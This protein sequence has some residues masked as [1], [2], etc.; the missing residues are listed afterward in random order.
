MQKV[1]IKYENRKLY[2]K[3]LKGY[4]SLQELENY[5]INNI[6]FSVIKHK[7]QEDITNETLVRVL[8]NKLNKSSNKS[9]D[10]LITLI[11][12]S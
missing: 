3:D 8:A 6:T 4:I 11:Q 7:T 12:K 1:I 9:T 2:D 5:A 10:S